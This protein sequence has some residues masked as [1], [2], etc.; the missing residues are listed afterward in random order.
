MKKDG[1]DI[2]IINIHGLFRGHSL[3]LGCDADTGG[4]TKYVLE[5]AQELGKDEHINN[6]YILT[7]KI[8][9][10]NISNDYSK[11]IEDID[12]NIKIFRI[13]C[14]GL[15]YIKKE[16]LWPHLNEFV[17]NAF[18]FL[19]TKNIFPHFIHSHYADAGYAAMKLSEKLNIPFIH[20]GH[21]LGIPKK[22]KLIE[23]GLSEQIIEKEYKINHRINIENKIIEK[24][25]IIIVS[26]NQEI[27]GQYALYDNYS[28]GRYIV[29][30]PGVDLDKFFP[31]YYM[32]E[33]R[34]VQLDEYEKCLQA[35]T[36]IKGELNRFF[37]HSEKPIILA[38]CRPEARKNI[39]GLI[40]AYGQDKE[41][42]I[43]ANLAIFAGIRK[44]ITDK[45]RAERETLTD[46]LL[47]M[48]KFDLY[49]KLAIPKK[50]DIDNE[51]PELY[52]YT[53]TLHG[54]FVNSAFIEPFGL[55]LIEAAA[56]GLPIVATN[57]GG[58]QDIIKYCNNGLLVDV[59]NSEKISRAIKKI[60]VNRNIWTKFSNYGIIN[61][62]KYYS[63]TTHCETLIET[64]ISKNLYAKEKKSYHIEDSLNKKF[65]KVK[66]V[67]I[68][69]IDNTLLG[70]IDLLGKL[71]DWLMPRKDKICFGVA[72]GRNFKSALHILQINRVPA[73]DILITSVGTEIYYLHKENKFYDQSWDTHI[74]YEWE[75]DKIKDIL[76]DLNYLKFQLDQRKYKISYFI[77]NYSQ[78]KISEIKSALDAQACSYNLI[79]AENWLLDILP[80]RASKYKAIVHFADRKNISKDDILVAG[81]SGND[82][83]MLQGFKN[84]VIVANHQKELYGLKNVYY[85]K[86]PN[87]GAIIDGLKKYGFWKI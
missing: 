77:K 37:L 10:K 87:A 58:P 48:D 54:V 40:T 35:R 31:Y 3:E 45:D 82:L 16:K 14:G 13:E 86:Y 4:Q 62:K 8:R 84:S 67:I 78:E 19:K 41:L 30:P 61:S 6:V 83:E 52:R 46:M 23:N 43:I 11:E 71:F 50:H 1:I 12:S 9:E 25:S 21:S 69:D 81:D 24:A 5:Y 80:V 17:Q 66:K 51:V 85:S 65:K 64:I 44:D 39:E 75:P 20:T 68:T 33:I 76:D 60:L 42:Q 18:E 32:E 59:S 55:T 56:S 70:N 49:G 57:N 34:K 47:L 79:A 72:T 36:S 27:K 28:K 7:R 15:S 53:A 38:I 63:W 26:T 2:L 29:I 73:P 74:N 22:V